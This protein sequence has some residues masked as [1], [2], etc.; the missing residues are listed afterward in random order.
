[1]LFI[2]YLSYSP[3]YKKCCSSECIIPNNPNGFH[4]HYDKALNNRTG[5]VGLILAED[6]DF[7]IKMYCILYNNSVGWIPIYEID[8]ILNDTND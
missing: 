3:T 7:N 6:D 4:L 2:F 5:D 1:M 8:R